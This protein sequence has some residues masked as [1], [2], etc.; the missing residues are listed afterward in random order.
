MTRSQARL[1]PVPTAW[2]CGEEVFAF[3]NS[4]WQGHVFPGTHISMNVVRADPRRQM[5]D[6]YSL[7]HCRQLN[8]TR[9]VEC[10]TEPG[11]RQTLE[12]FKWRQHTGD[13]PDRG[14]VAS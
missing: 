1:V 14:E 6:G 13:S 8:I 7:V 9:S 4:P 5:P 3:N 11:G 10:F 12:G 2:L